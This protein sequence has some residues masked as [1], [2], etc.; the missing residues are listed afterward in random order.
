MSS[1]PP[2]V[3]EGKSPVPEA[4]LFETSLATVAV[5]ERLR[6]GRRIEVG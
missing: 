2:G 5:V 6:E 1:R 3:C 4:E